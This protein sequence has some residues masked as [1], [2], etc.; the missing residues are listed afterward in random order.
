VDHELAR[1]FDHPTRAEI[2]DALAGG[3]ATPRQLAAALGQGLSTISYHVTMLHQFR[4][5]AVAKTE[6]HRGAIEREYELVPPAS[7]GYIPRQHVPP[8]L[9]DYASG[10]VLQ[11]I[12][13][14]GVTALAAGTLDARDDSHLMCLSF[15]FDEQGWSEAD[16]LVRDTR[17]RLAAIL[18][19]STS[20]LAKTKEPGTPT[21]VVLANFESAREG[22]G[23]GHA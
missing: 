17:T 4:C 23:N 13:D 19:R 10:A 22:R 8:P 5:I 20:R 21:T 3:T 9:R 12:M 7:T 2:V 6:R 18:A 16:E 15:A 14:S 1:A 11:Q